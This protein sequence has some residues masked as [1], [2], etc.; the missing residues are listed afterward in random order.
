[1]TQSLITSTVSESKIGHIKDLLTPVLRRLLKDDDQAQTLIEAGNTL[2]DRFTVV[3]TALVAKLANTFMVTVDYTRSLPDMITAGKYD[4]VSYDITTDHFPIAGTRKQDLEVVLIHF[5]K[6]MQSDDV[7]SEL[8][9]QGLRAA[10]LP[11]L[12]AFGE[13]HPEVQ[14]EF[15][16]ITLG[17]IWQRRSGRRSIPFLGFCH[18]GRELDLY[19]F[20]FWWHRRCR[21]AAVRK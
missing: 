14:R 3:V 5:G 10:T 7:L 8:D 11:E 2:Q 18:G 19:W 4:S 15:T 17:S 21:F 20:E 9:K 6:D 12:L 1:M 13:T 16:I